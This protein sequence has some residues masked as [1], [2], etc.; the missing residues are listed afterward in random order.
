MLRRMPK[1]V[2]ATY[3][4]NGLSRLVFCAAAIYL[5]FAA[6]IIGAQTPA[7]KILSQ[8]PGEQWEH[9]ISE[10][11]TSFEY[12]VAGSNTQADF[13]IGVAIGYKFMK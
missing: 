6:N 12:K 5:V 13:G 4:D 10:K 2:R 11:S 7:S 8:I 3:F 1:P 9:I